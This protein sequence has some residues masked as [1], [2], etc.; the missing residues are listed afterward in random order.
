MA[1][2]VGQ[3]LVKIHTAAWVFKFRAGLVQGLNG[4]FVRELVLVDQR[5]QLMSVD[6]AELVVVPALGT[7]PQAEGNTTDRNALSSSA[8]WGS[9]H[10]SSERA[11]RQGH[12]A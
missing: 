3:E 2:L 4:I 6:V 10:S 12:Q 9:L 1:E 7:R 11:H 8:H 5:L